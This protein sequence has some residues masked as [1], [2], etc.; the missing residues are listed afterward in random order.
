MWTGNQL[1]DFIQ[2]QIK[3]IINDKIMNALIQIS[4]NETPQYVYG[5]KGVAE[6]FGVSEHTAHNY[7]HSWLA[8][9]V[10]RRGKVIIT[11][12][13]EAMELFAGKKLKR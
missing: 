12:T 4:K 8:P 5:I 1:L 6:L 10:M 2:E 13:K 9:A 3:P 11:K 7:I